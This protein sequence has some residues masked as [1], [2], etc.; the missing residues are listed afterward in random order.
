M[1][2]DLSR[3]MK[4]AIPIVALA[5]AMILACAPAAPSPTTAPAKPAATTAAPASPAASPVAKPAAS[6]G[7]SPAASPAAAA[8]STS[9]APA[10]APAVAKL[11]DF[12]TKPIEIIVPFPPGG[13]YDAQA[14]QLAIPLQKLLG[15]PVVVKNIPGGGGRLGAREFQRAPADG[16]TLHYG[17]D[18]GL[19]Q[20]NMVEPPEGFDVNN[21]VWAVGIRKMPGTIMA[22]KDSPYKTI[23]ELI[24]AGR[25]GTRI[26]IPNNGVAGGYFANNVVMVAALGIT[27]PVHVGGFGGTGDIIPSLVRGDTEVVA[28]VAPVSAMQFVRNGDLRVL[29]ALESQRIGILPDVPTARELALPNSEDL[30]AIGSS[31]SGFAVQPGT[32]AERVRLIEQAT[33]AAMQD[34][35]FLA[36]ATQ[37]GAYPTEMAGVPGAQYTEMKKREYAFWRKYE[38]A[39]KKAAQ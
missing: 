14:R 26:R 8:P 3:I 29:L 32:P 17:T 31:T 34:P 25:A 21:W 30:E 18:T 13:G 2:L 5:T 11:P 1:A 10:S 39:I 38:D 7:A 37:S 9:A 6:P 35:E 4:R 15:Q 23:Q 24:A 16:Y 36:W 28:F 19:V 20:G 27:N 22:G 12:P 33:L